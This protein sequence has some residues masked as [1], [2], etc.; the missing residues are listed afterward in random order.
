MQAKSIKQAVPESVWSKGSQA[1]CEYLIQ[2]GYRCV[3]RAHGVVARIDRIDWLQHLSKELMVSESSLYVGS[4]IDPRACDHYRRVYS[5]DR[6]CLSDLREACL[7]ALYDIRA[8]P[9]SMDDPAGFIDPDSLEEK[10]PLTLWDRLLPELEEL[11]R[12]LSEFSPSGL[13]SARHQ[14]EY[15]IEKVKTRTL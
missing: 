5:K 15:L 2:R 12:R 4:D 14:A 7:E 11:R 6:V 3:S 13:V 10:A 9:S 1:V 8:Y